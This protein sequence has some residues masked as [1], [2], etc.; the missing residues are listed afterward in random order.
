MRSLYEEE[1][2]RARAELE[3]DGWEMLPTDT[4]PVPA[5]P[6]TEPVDLA[7][8]LIARRGDQY[9]VV[10]IKSRRQARIEDYRQLT[11][12]L[13]KHPNWRVDLRWI[14]RDQPVPAPIADLNRRMAK[15]RGLMES[16]PEAALLL[17]WAAVEGLA[18]T[19]LQKG[20]PSKSSDLRALV[21]ELQ[22]AGYLSDT[23]R[24]VVTGLSVRRNALAHGDQSSPISSDDL[25]RLLD[26]GT[27]LMR[28]LETPGPLLLDDEPLL[29]GLQEYPFKAFR[30]AE[31]DV[32]A[33]VTE[34]RENASL[35]NA[36][37]RIFRVVQ[38]RF[39]GAQVIEHWLTEP[40]FGPYRESD[41]AGS[42][43]RVTLAQVGLEGVVI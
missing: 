4:Q 25:V 12:N 38:E 7:A 9:L 35:M 3:A 32:V 13:A 27:I 39:P 17:G 5:P 14:G 37:E 24:R 19:L 21:A 40:D 16:E 2:L 23:D 11:M 34:M 29:L 43:K 28:S 33:V 20:D 6:M 42:S 10:V 15:A 8:D 18:K 22:D 41:G 1:L 26:V 31:G 36:S 30:T